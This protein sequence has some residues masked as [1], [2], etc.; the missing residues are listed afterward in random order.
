M[1]SAKPK[2]NT[3][4]SIGIFLSIAYGATIYF[5]IDISQSNDPEIF[6][7]L[8]LYAIG[9]IAVAVT[10]KTL[11]GVKIVTINKEKFDVQYPFRFKKMKFSGKDLA[12]WSTESI[13]TYG[14]IYEEMILVTNE[15][16]KISLSKQEHSDYD[17]TRQYMLKKFKR[18]QK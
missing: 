6:T 18:I 2:A 9:S 5:A 13:K 15:G 16:K 3:L 8:L 11:W 14:G 4:F 17:K 7:Y 10:L 12:Y 1:I